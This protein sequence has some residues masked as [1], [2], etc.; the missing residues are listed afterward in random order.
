M[1]HIKIEYEGVVYHFYTP[2]DESAPHGIKPLFESKFGNVGQYTYRIDPPH[3][4]ENGQKH[5]HFMDK[6]GEIFALNKDGSAHDGWHG[7][8][9]P[10]KVLAELPNIMPGLTIPKNGLIECVLKTCDSEEETILYG[11][12]LKEAKTENYL[13]EAA[14]YC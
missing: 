12:F 13:N 11:E 5:I 9:I 8:Q 10:N 1:R 7:V 3:N 6:S 4:S 14:K 2:S